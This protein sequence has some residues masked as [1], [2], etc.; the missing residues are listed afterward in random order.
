MM[1][2]QFV[3]LGISLISVGQVA[4]LF[5]RT[6]PTNQASL[7]QNDCNATAR[8]AAILIKRQ[9]LMNGPSLI[10]DASFFPTG[11]LANTMIQTAIGQFE[12][13]EAPL[14][15]E[16]QSDLQL[17]GAAVATVG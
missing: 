13:D 7:P 10:G 3:T 2:V 9:N 8:A 11:P 4:A 12:G 15:A 17:A 16:I 5:P 6:C 1:F 14:S